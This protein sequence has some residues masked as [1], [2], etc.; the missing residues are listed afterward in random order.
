M[1]AIRIPRITLIAVALAV[2]SRAALVGGGAVAPSLSTEERFEQPAGQRLIEPLPPSPTPAPFGPVALSITVSGG[3]SLGAYQGGYLYYL[4]QVARA[5]PESIDI[6]VASGSSAGM[7]NA[8]LLIMAL[9]AIEDEKPDESVLFRVWTKSTFDDL[10]DVENAPPLALSSRRE[11]ERTAKWLEA[12]WSKGLTPNVDVV[13][14]AAATRLASRELEVSDGFTVPKQEEKFTLRIRGQGKGKPPLVE[15]YVDPTYGAEQPLLPLS[16]GL[17]RVPDVHE[18]FDVLRRLLFASSA[19][20][21]FFVPQEIHYCLT[22]PQSSSSSKECLEPTHKAQFIDGAL[23]DKQPL[24]LAYRLAAAGL[25]TQLDGTTQWR[26]VPNMAQGQLPSTAHFLLL[27]PVRSTYPASE[28]EEETEASL[29]QAVHF[30]AEWGRFLKE[31]VAS[32]RNKEVS[33]LHEEHPAVRD[34]LRI[35]TSDFPLASSPLLN[36]FGFFDRKLR[37]FDF[38]LGMRDARAYLERWQ[39]SSKTLGPHGDG[40]ALRFPEPLERTPQMGTSGWAPFLCLREV[41]DA[42]PPR[43]SACNG[44]H[45]FRILLQTAFDRLYDHCRALPLEESLSHTHCRKAMQGADPPRIVRAED[46]SE[47]FWRQ[48]D[49]E[50]EFHYVARLL[51]GYRFKFEDL[52]LDREDAD[53]ATS[54][55]RT[56]ILNHLDAYAKKLESGDRL[57]LRLLGKPAVNFF[58]YAPPET[59]VYL[60]AGRGAEVAVSATL[61]RSYWLRYNFALQ[62]QGVDVLLTQ[63]PNVLA[64]TPMVGLEAE[65][66]PLSSPLLQSRFG[67]RAGY[68]FS[69]SD[70]FTARPCDLEALDRDARRCSALVTQAFTAFSFYER[71]RLQVGF[72]WLPRWAPPMRDNDRNYYNVLLEVGFQWLSPF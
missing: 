55:I 15:N 56:H 33:T 45:D 60:V 25:S 43:P 41:I 18:D 23:A 58:V 7:V 59:I 63:A 37:T 20:P 64:L 1:T 31:Y 4:A 62:V 47:G 72:E 36:F 70:R 51:E 16:G 14:G 46:E 67:I 24:R 54:R 61:G 10:F 13:L 42:D 17:G 12:E 44:L 57:A 53:L 35:A 6:K 22:D 5:N 3:V 29:E 8:L 28:Q 9:G 32:A 71:I 48:A 65:I 68:Q 26:D 52:G 2:L 27:D 66:Y 38:Y 69:T 50:G 39:A 34:R 11:L 21:I 49:E 30:F 40:M 19:I